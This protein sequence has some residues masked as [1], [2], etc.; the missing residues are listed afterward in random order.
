MVELL[1][2]DLKT[3]KK[4]IL[5]AAMDFTPEQS[6][7]F[8]PIYREYD[9]EL[10]KLGDGLIALVKDYAA[11]YEQMTDVK[12]K[13]L[14]ERSFKLEEQRLKLRQTYT[15]KFEKAMDTVTAA[16]FA[17]VERQLVRISNVAIGGQRSM[18]H[19]VIGLASA[20]L[21]PIH[22]DEMLF[23]GA[24]SDARYDH[25][26]SARAA[27]KKEQYGF[28]HVVSANRNP[29]LTRI[30]LHFFQRGDRARHR[31]ATCIGDGWR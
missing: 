6:E 30:Q 19:R 29:L 16:R 25:V 14:T 10:S 7:I 31:F 11:N 21:I 1:R 23:E 24:E 3:E 20:G 8:W 27:R 15:K 18:R 2:S 13:E 17:Q 28:V 22:H 9:L 26:R 12:A 4:A 5:T